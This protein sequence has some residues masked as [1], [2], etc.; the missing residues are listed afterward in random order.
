LILIQRFMAEIESGLRA[1]LTCCT[2]ER[3]LKRKGAPAVG[4]ML[5]QEELT[6]I[7]AISHT[8]L[9]S[10]FLR[11]MRK[12]M[13]AAKKK[14]KKK[15]LA[16]SKANATSASALERNNGVRSEA[17]TFHD[18]PQPKRKAEELSSSDSPSEPANRRPA[19]GHLFDDGPGAKGTM[20]KL[21]AQSSRQLG[22]TEGGPA[23]AAMVAGHASPQQ[24][25]GT[26]KSLTKGSD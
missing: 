26:H 22:S 25:S 20:G 18:L 15:A 9:S 10:V 13:A 21:A 8:E 2:E 7:K 16:A 24:P 17:Q 4:A 6:F 19:S 3:V 5:K 1:A 11:E 14:K 12:A 23:F